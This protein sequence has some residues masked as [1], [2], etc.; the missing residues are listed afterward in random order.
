MA[1]EA[2]ARLAPYAVAADVARKRLWVGT[3]QGLVALD[4]ALK[5]VRRVH[6]PTLGGRNVTSVAV[7]PATGDVFAVAADDGK[8]A[9]LAR[10]AGTTVTTLV[11]GEAQCPGA[12]SPRSRSRRATRR[13]TPPWRAGR[14]QRRRGRLGRH[15][16]GSARER[17]RPRARGEGQDRSLRSLRAR[18][19]RHGRSA[20]DRR[21]PA[22]ASADAAAGWARVDLARQDGRRVAHRP[23]AVERPARHPRARGR[24]RPRHAAHLHR[25][26]GAVSDTK[27]PAAAGPRSPSRRPARCASSARSCR[28]CAPSRAR[29]GRHVRRA[30]R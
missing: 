19:G 23:H 22:P 14:G 26:D 24:L 17:G 10:L 30:P 16:G 9:K 4:D 13:P 6:G 25:G 27:L 8:P 2:G 3:T 1:D 11:A 21:A 20:R 5:I 29:H 15:D 7:D 12:A 18:G 28:V